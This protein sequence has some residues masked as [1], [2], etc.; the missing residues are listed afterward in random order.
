MLRP[1]F[2]SWKCYFPA[3][4]PSFAA[5]GAL[6]FFLSHE[7]TMS[8]TEENAFPTSREYLLKPRLFEAL[9]SIAFFGRKLL[10][11]NLDR[12][13]LTESLPSVSFHSVQYPTLI[14]LVPAA[15]RKP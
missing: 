8:S 15:E 5:K 7:S 3:A 14:I 12:C 10:A 13:H 11:Q 4:V 2:H 1:P 9:P 6:S